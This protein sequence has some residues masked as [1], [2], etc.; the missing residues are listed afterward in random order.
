MC[1]RDRGNIDTD[2]VFADIEQYEYYVSD[3]SDCIGGGTPDLAPAFD[4]E[5]N[6]R[7]QTPT[8]G[9][10]EIGRYIAA[11]HVIQT[12]A[13][14]SGAIEPAGD[15]SVLRMSDQ[16]FQI[17]EQTGHLLTD[18]LV[19]GESI[20]PVTDYNFQRVK[21]NHTIEAKFKSYPVAF[22]IQAVSQTYQGEA[23]EIELTLLNVRQEPTV[24]L[25]PITIDLSLEG[26][27]GQ[28]STAA[29]HQKQSPVT[30]ITIP[31]DETSTTAFFQTHQLCQTRIDIRHRQS[32][33][34]LSAWASDMVN[35]EVAS[36]THALTVITA[37]EEIK[38]SGS[39]INIGQTATITLIG[40]SADADSF[41]VA[42]AT[43]SIPGLVESQKAYASVEDPTRYVGYFLS[44]IHI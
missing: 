3:Q 26:S 13:D 11:K 16:S 23:I 40:K 34:T 17:L 2:P 21:S 1:I 36:A 9:A 14:L 31:T 8:I 22:Q 29:N 4:F 25:T 43:F 38:V 37:L 35:P 42:T 12:I 18:I 30:E 39:P 20:G 5:G 32:T 19:D 33:E 6:P 10:Y 44:L 7:S 41:D 28:F 24:P 15:I 27:T